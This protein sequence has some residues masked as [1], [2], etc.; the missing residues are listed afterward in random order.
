MK[1]VDY[2]LSGKDWCMGS[3]RKTATAM[4]WDPKT[5]DDIAFIAEC[6]LQ[7]DRLQQ[8]HVFVTIR[9]KYVEHMFD[10][11]ITEHT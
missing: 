5:E 7:Q 9:F 1:L 10:N 6:V 4:D 8:E 11:E 3:K 2:I